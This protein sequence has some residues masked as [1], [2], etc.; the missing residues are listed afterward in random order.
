MMEN[1]IIERA[2][3]WL[4]DGFDEAT[5]NEVKRMLE[6]DP[7]ALTDSFYRQL[8]F[9]TGGLR[10]IMGAGTNRMNIYTV[11]M[12]T[13]GLSNYLEEVFKGQQ[14]KVAI[15]HDCR[16]NSQ[17]FARKAAEVFA[18]NGIKVFLFKELRPTPELSYAIRQLGC[19][20]GLVITA[21]HN[22]KEYNGYKVYW[23][24]GGQLVPPHDKNII[25]EVEKIQLANIASPQKQ[26]L[27]ENIIIIGEEIDNEYLQKITSLSLS[28]N[29]IKK[30]KA[31][32]IVYTS[33]HG[34]GITLVPKMLKQFGFENVIIVEEQSK[35]D[36]NF[37]T[38][39]SPNPEENEALELALRKAK[40]VNAELVMGTDPDADRVGIAVKNLN[41][42]LVLLNGNQ[43]GSLLIYYLLRRYK[44]LGKL[45]GK[46]FIAKTIVTTGLM[47]QIAA[48]FDVKCYNVL[49]GFKYIAELIKTLE[50]QEQF[51]GGGEESYG[52]LVGDFVRDKDAISSCA[53]IAEMFAWA[54]DNNMGLFDL[55]IQLY[56]Q[57]GFYKE[58]LLSLTKKGKEGVA[59]IEK[60]MENFRKSPPQTIG[61][62]SVEII[63]DYLIEQ[64][65]YVISG[66][67]EPTDLPR[68]NVIQFV[69][70]DHTII[71]VRPSGTEPKIKFYFSVRQ[72]LLSK[73][74]FEKVNIQL[75]KKIEALK[76]EMKALAK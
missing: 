41:D 35:T 66:D 22:P 6:N 8:E 28:P 13:Q 55:L 33:L 11:S 9:G 3:T 38:V 67:I 40:E 21:S 5:R 29:I 64:E 73:N 4:S 49:T 16:N 42:Q 63:K 25:S 59:E 36:G 26:Q 61:S 10:G 30:H 2:K 34:T 65:D 58:G 69:M 31:L 7:A 45:N 18:A 62:S 37:P 20:S 74:D 1:E 50:G 17:L 39:A 44:E 27:E 48:G 72:E 60:M 68:S 51:I 71:T 53:F 32:K 43:T 12:A 76:E 54:K 24:D 56:M 47:E 19:Q 14:I 52:Y 57:F 23:D 75:D 46:Q 15:A 70:E